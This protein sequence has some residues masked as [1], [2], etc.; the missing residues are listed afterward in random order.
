MFSSKLRQLLSQTA[1]VNSYPAAV[2]DHAETSVSSVF[3]GPLYLAVV[4]FGA[5]FSGHVLFVQWGWDAETVAHTKSL[6]SAFW[7]ADL[8]RSIQDHV[9]V[10]QLETGAQRWQNDANLKLFGVFSW[11]GWLALFSAVD[12]RI[13]ILFCTVKTTI[14][15]VNQARIEYIIT[16]LW[17]S[18][19]IACILKSFDLHNYRAAQDRL[20]KWQH[21]TNLHVRF[22]GH[23][24]H[25]VRCEYVSE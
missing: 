22:C 17:I 18:V 23:H 2:G 14:I 1:S 7:M 8:N 3:I 16:W 21:N 25:C 24:G 11:G 4:P 13:Y 12:T 20:L 10:V 5:N 15:K 9:P 6:R 19:I